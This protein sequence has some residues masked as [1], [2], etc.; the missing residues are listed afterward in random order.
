MLRGVKGR[1]DSGAG[2]VR[3]LESH[4]SLFLRGWRESETGGEGVEGHEIKGA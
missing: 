2:S 4:E 1:K 3:G